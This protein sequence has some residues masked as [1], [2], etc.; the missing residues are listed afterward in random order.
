MIYLFPPVL[1]SLKFLLKLPI[2]SNKETSYTLLMYKGLLK[3]LFLASL[4][5]KKGK[6][7]KKRR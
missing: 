1:N 5:L 6:D 3:G 2:N 7:T 4:K